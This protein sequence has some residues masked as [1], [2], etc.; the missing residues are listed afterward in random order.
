MKF[1][2]ASGDIVTVHVDQKVARECYIASFKF[3]PTNQLRYRVSPR[4]QSREHREDS[5]QG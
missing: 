1:P 2:S 4:G 3:E 5:H